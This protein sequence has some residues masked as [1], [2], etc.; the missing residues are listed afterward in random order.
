MAWA[1]LDDIP[2]NA[3]APFTD[4]AK[5]RLEVSDGGRH[6]WHYLCTDEEYERWPQNT[7]DK[8]WLGLPTN[9][10]DLPPAEDALSAA[11][12]G[13]R[14]Y[15]NL[16]SDDGHWAGEFGGPMFLLPGLVLG[17]YVAGM[18]FTREERLEMIRYLLNRANPDD[19][20]WGIHTE[21][22]STVF[23]TALNYCSMRILGVDAEHP[24]MIKARGTL[25][26]LGGAT[27]IPSWGK[28]WLSV[29]NVHDWDGCNPI[30]PELWLLPEWLPV[31]PSK[32]WVHTRSV[33]IPM[34]YLY[35]VRFQAEEND[36]I[37]S[38]RKELY[39]EDYDKIDWPAHR[40]SIAPVDLF[41]P[42]SALLKSCDAILGAYESCNLPPARNIALSRVYQL[43]CFEDENTSYQSI[44]PVSKMLNLVCRFH[45]EGRDGEAF[46]MHDARRRDFM[47]MGEDGMRVCGTNGSQLW[48]TAFITQ[49]VVEGGLAED[50]EGE[51]CESMMKALDWLEKCQ[52]QNN[53]CHY[54]NA[55]RHRTKGA[56]P[57]ST[58]EQGYTVSD[59]TA[60]GLKAIL[61]LQEH[62]TY[63]SK[64]VPEQRLRDAVDTMLS[65]QNPGGG[66]ASFELARGSALLEVINPAEVFGDIM[67]E[68]PYPECTTSVITALSIFRKYYPHYRGEDIEDATKRA[69]SY[70]HSVQRPDGS[71]YGSWG[72]C[73]TYATMF[74][75]ESLALNGETFG[76]SERVQ[77]ACQFL[78]S[79][80]MEDGG[81]GETYMSCVTGEY[82]QHQKSQVVQTAWAVLALIYAEY[83]NREPVEKGVRLVMSRQLPDGSW[84]Q[85]SIEG[86][87][88]KNCAISYPNFKFSFT[89]WM[90]GKAHHYLRSLKSS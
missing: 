61:Y 29:L 39:V 9:L 69:I 75:L 7:V 83:S 72:I 57:F 59:C 25:H 47:W 26:K 44:A 35:G 11:R 68:Y 74:A 48:D 80:Q 2:A 55:Y 8:Y 51:N 3:S 82:A 27:G 1:P 41:A 38:L 86:I 77:K 32:W 66:V 67:I 85:E 43:I 62:L 6:I 54:E 79:K 37:L 89:I 60:E 78:T 73:F 65:M 50:P 84:A 42:H 19:G 20:G 71:W 5:W 81:W 21:G 31:H 12:N 23:G 33:Y 76:S 88:N 70:L 4:Y 58:K 64:L 46:R 40:N 56:W 24:A 49:A 28:F 34:S 22:C 30:P 52:I 87:F 63:T 14:F 13:F 15:R 90:L 18:T 53:P 16:Q 36:L 45:K 10:P 17:S